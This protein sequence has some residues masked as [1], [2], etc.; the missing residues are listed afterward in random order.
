MQSNIRHLENQ[1]INLMQ[2]K[3]SQEQ[4]INDYKVKRGENEEK[5][6]KLSKDL[7]ENKEK[8]EAAEQV[9][10]IFDILLEHFLFSI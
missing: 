4:S 6:K 3:T 10:E 2:T 8:L 7:E 9:M 1:V 5:I